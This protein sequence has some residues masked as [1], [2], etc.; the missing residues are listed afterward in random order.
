MHEIGVVSGFSAAYKLGAKYPF[1]DD[2]N[3][4]RLFALYLAASHGSRMRSEDRDG[5]FK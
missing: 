5:F 3:C 2:A 4:K 1:K